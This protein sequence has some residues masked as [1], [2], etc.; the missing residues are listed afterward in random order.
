MVGKE[1]GPGGEGGVERG[2]VGGKGREGYV[3]L[4]RVGGAKRRMK[5]YYIHSFILLRR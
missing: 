1:E 4:G 5:V 2:G 3:G